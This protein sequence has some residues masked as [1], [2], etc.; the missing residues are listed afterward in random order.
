MFPS[1]SSWVRLVSFCV[2]KTNKRHY[3]SGDIMYQTM[4]GTACKANEHLKKDN[5]I[6]LKLFEG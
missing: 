4:Q 1:S 6:N 2:Y 3:I 5:K